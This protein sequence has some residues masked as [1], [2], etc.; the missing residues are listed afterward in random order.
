MSAGSSVLPCRDHPPVLEQTSMA[1]IEFT[2]NYDDLSTDRAYQ[3][4]FYCEKCGNGYLSTFQSSKLGL[5]ASAASVA[6]NLFGGLFGRVSDTAYEIQ[7]A[8]GGPAHDAALKEAV[9]APRARAAPGSAPSAGRKWRR[10]AATR[11]GRHA[12]GSRPRQPVQACP[13]QLV[14]GGFGALAADFAD[15][16]LGEARLVAQVDE[17][18]DD[19]L[20]GGGGGRGGLGQLGGELAHLVL[21]LQHHALGG[22]LA[23]AGDGGEAADVAGGDGA[24]QVVRRHAG[25]RHPRQARADA[26]DGDQPLEEELLPLGPEAEQGDAVLAHVGVDEEADGLVAPLLDLVPGREGDVDLVAHAVDVEQPP[27]G[28][29]LQQLALEVADH[30][31]GD[32]TGVVH[33]SPV[34]ESP[35]PPSSTLSPATAQALE[36]P[37]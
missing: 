22:L 30:G 31:Q 4:K 29:G 15:G 18:G 8:V 32:C 34:S 13:Q 37:S 5:A 19:V 28:C 11:Y 16:A 26:G 36:L 12:S 27:P 20:V 21:E 35:F 1:N 24:Q 2:G 17:G 10:G 25:E 33:L 3:F 14:E 7:R 23:H 9:A 6:G